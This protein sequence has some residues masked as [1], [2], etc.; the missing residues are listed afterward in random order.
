MRHPN[1]RGNLARSARA[2]TRQRVL[3]PTMLR[4]CPRQVAGTILKVPSP[5]ERRRAQRRQSQTRSGTERRR[6]ERGPDRRQVDRRSGMDRRQLDLQVDYG[7]RTIPVVRC[8]G[9]ITLG[10]AVN[11]FV[12][13]CTGLLKGRALIAVDLQ[14][15]THIDSTGVGALLSVTTSARRNGDVKL[16]SPSKKVENAL[17]V[18]YLY[19]LFE[20]FA[21]PEEAAE[22]VRQALSEAEETV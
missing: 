2:L 7:L 1:Q 12:A 15:I 8:S 6:Y 18:T 17:R 4:S 11:N 3:S 22:K 9:R 19:D 16:V 14:N 13:T 5:M 21:T 10:N 20:V